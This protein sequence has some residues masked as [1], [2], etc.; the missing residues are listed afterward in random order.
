MFLIT[1]EG[2]KYRLCQK[3]EERKEEHQRG[4]RSPIAQTIHYPVFIP[5]ANYPM[6]RPVINDQP[7]SPLPSFER[8]V[9]RHVYE[10]K[11]EHH[12]RARE[13]Y[14]FGDV[15]EHVMAH[16]VADYEQRL[17]RGHVLNRGVPHDDAL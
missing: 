17:R 6:A 9:H 7:P 14:A 5:I 2:I 1:A 12:K 13:G 16:L 4:Q 3:N 8:P 10:I 11:N 15:A